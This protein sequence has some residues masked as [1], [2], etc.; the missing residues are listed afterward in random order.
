MD[1]RR[2]GLGVSRWSL[3]VGAHNASA[4]NG[5]IG[6][7]TISDARRISPDA[8][9]GKSHSRREQS[10]TRNANG[11]PCGRVIGRRC[12]QRAV[13]TPSPDLI[14]RHLCLPS[15]SPLWGQV[16]QVLQAPA[17]RPPSLDR[18]FPWVAGKKG[19][20][21]N[22]TLGRNFFRASLHIVPRKKVGVHGLDQNNPRLRRWYERRV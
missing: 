8:R 9:R 4:R 6:V 20:S 14:R 21:R 12:G 11:G 16:P 22:S 3:M 19:N 7:S 5:T 15:H 10:Q 17:S 1:G 13:L 18:V 2:A